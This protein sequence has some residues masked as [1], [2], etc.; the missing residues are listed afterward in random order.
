MV[1]ADT[2]EKPSGLLFEGPEWDFDKLR[3]VV[4]MQVALRPNRIGKPF[5]SANGV[6]ELN[7]GVIAASRTEVGDQLR[8]E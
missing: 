8:F 3:R 5:W 2:V 6:I 7:T 1:A 4:G